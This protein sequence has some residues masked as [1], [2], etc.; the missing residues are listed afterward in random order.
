MVYMSVASV[1]DETTV[2]RRRRRPATMKVPYT[3]NE[4]KK[5]T[6]TQRKY[7]RIFCRKLNVRKR[8]TKRH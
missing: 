8:R 3:E 5:E 6:R 1:G 7:V 2:E 4:Q